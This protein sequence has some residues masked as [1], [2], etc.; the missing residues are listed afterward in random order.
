MDIKS[1]LA[2][3]MIK[4]NSIQFG[5]FKL[6]SGKESPYYID[7]RILP[8]FPSYF[9][10]AID[11]FSNALKDLNFDYLCSIPTGGLIYA[12]ILSYIFAKPLIYVRKEPKGYGMNKLIEGYIKP[13]ADVVIIDDVITTGQTIINAINAINTNGGIVSHVIV[14]IDRLEGAKRR[15][16]SMN[17]N[18]ISI[19]TI[20]DIIEILY[21]RDIINNSTYSIINEQIED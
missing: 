6:S 16:A 15:L 9:K 8:S 2:E 1:E 21:N 13:G 12:S 17:V 19:C 10:V 14:L 20:K 7:L 11:A 4:S 3:F 18:L 5:L